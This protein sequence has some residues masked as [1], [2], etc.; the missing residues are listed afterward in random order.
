MASKARLRSLECHQ[1]I[2]HTDFLLVHHRNHI[3]VL[4]SVR[5]TATYWPSYEYICIYAVTRAC[6]YI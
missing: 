5:D 6:R 1:L 3:F 4:R 2:E